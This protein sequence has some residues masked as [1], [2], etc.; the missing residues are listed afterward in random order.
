MNEIS[1]ESETLSNRVFWSA[2]ESVRARVPCRRNV[3]RVRLVCVVDVIKRVDFDIE[4]FK[5]AASD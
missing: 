4:D 1:F 5:E 2:V 3:L